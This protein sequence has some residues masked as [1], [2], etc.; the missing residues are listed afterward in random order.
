[1]LSYYPTCRSLASVSA[2]MNESKQQKTAPVTVFRSS[3]GWAPIGLREMWRYRELLWVLTLRSVQI[4]YK[5]SILGIAWAVLQPLALMLMFTLIFSVLLKVPSD[6]VP[7]PIFSYSA[8]LFWTFFSNSL[9]HAIPSLQENAPLIRKIYFPR[10]FFPMS[11]ILAAVFDLL[12]ASLIFLGLMFYYNIPFTVNIL[13]VV[14]VLI[15]QTVFTMGVCF[16]FSALN[17]YYRDVKYALPLVIQL[18]LYATPI[19]YPISSVPERLRLYYMLNPM[20]GIIESYRNVLVKG[21][22]P[23]SFYMAVAAAGAVLLFILG[24]IYFKRI[25]MTLADVV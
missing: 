10:E 25:E 12:I 4:R 2:A 5:Q 6:G 17:A 9:S 19:I 23:S 20:T 1:M 7:Y 13:Y 15:I 22:P 3:Q 24:Y 16:I 21:L 14:P 18:W 11:S 8:L